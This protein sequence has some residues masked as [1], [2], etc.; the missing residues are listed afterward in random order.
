GIMGGYGLLKG[1]AWARILVLIL[2]VFDL[3]EF[4][5]GTVVAAYTI[6]VL[7]NNE[8]S[9]F[10]DGDSTAKSQMAFS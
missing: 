8:T 6:W 2:A 9:Q 4:P 3:F 5:I 1:K 7:L 10:F